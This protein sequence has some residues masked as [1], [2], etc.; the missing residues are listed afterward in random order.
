MKTALLA[1]HIA[2]GQE[3]AL[4]EKHGVEN[5]ERWVTGHSGKSLH[6]Q[7]RVKVK[8]VWYWVPSTGKSVYLSDSPDFG[9]RPMYKTSYGYNEAVVNYDNSK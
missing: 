5:V 4:I 8:G 6:M 7:C 3:V 2:I 9:F 1:R